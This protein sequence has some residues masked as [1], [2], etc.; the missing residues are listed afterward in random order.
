MNFI[1]EKVKEAGSQTGVARK[2][3]VSQGTITKICNGDTNP[4]LGTI[5]KIAQAYGLNPAVFLQQQ[6]IQVCDPQPT[7]QPITADEQAILE[8]LKG[9][10][11]L[12]RRARRFVQFEKSA[13]ASEISNIEKAA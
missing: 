7:Y 1:K 6:A 9:D 3:G 12:A 13:D 11:D 10:P 5:Y 4:E 8:M 2:T